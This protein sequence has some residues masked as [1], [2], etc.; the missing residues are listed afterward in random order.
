MSSRH[1]D[2]ADELKERVSQ[3]IGALPTS[4]IT[5]EECEELVEQLDYSIERTKT[6]R[7]YYKEEDY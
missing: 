6:F 4:Y 3:L 7:K 2:I 1:K 5:A